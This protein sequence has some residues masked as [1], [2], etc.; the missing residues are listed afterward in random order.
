MSEKELMIFL[1]YLCVGLI[2]YLHY[3]GT[4]KE[5][6][7]LAVHFWIPH[8]LP[9]FARVPLHILSACFMILIGPLALISFLLRELMKIFGIP[10]FGNP[11][12]PDKE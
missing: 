6:N 2:T 9:F 11:Y 3:I 1:A 4:I 7:N 12:P 8:T 5:Q 10:N